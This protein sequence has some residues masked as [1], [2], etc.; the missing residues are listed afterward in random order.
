MPVSDS[1]RLRLSLAGWTAEPPRQ[2]LSH[3]ASSEAPG[4]SSDSVC[5][6]S[7]GTAQQCGVNNL[8]QGASWQSCHHLLPTIRFGTWCFSLLSQF[9]VLCSHLAQV[10]AAVCHTSG[11]PVTALFC[12]IQQVGCLHSKSTR[13]ALF[14]SCLDS[15]TLLSHHWLQLAP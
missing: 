2:A 11:T 7:N 15:I 6:T 8:K 10:P 1:I 14:L 12:R 9:S 4:G 13:C 3:E 5:G